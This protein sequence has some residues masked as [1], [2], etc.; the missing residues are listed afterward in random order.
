MLLGRREVLDK[1]R[2]YAPCLITGL[3]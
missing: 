1:L 3:T 2:P